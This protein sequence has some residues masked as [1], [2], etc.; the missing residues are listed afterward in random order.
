[1]IPLRL[2]EIGSATIVR[3]DPDLTITDVVTD[4]RQTRPDALFVCLRGE[5]HDGHDFAAEAAA[6]GAVA[7]LCERGRGTCAPAVP[8]LEAVNP[9]AALGDLARRVRRRSLAPVV[10]IAGAAG[11]TSTKDVL[12]ALLAPQLPTV[13]S[14]ASYNNEL[15]VP[16]TLA[17]LEPETAACVCELGTGAP[18]ELARLCRIAEPSLGVITAIGPEHLEFFGSAEAVAAE[19]AALIAALPSGAPLVLP[20][21]EDLLAPHRRT[22][23]D[24]WT[25]GLDERADVRPVAW[26]KA[27]A[28]TDARFLVRARPLAFTTNLRLPH[29]R[30]TLA[31]AIAAYAALG[32]PLERI[33]D[34]AARIALS[35]GRGEERRL[36]CGALLIDDAYNAN[37]VS[38][39]AGLEALVSRRNGGRAVAVLGGMAELGPQASRLH[40]RAA[41]QAAALGVDLLVAVGPA[42]RAY[43]DGATGQLE[44]R[45]LV[46]LDAATRALPA[47]LRPADV[48]LLKGS[49]ST[50]V[51]QLA[52]VLVD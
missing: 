14:P 39:A 34:G 40:A 30:L 25:F 43:L 33:V 42:A 50:G 29:H 9:L 37:P 8:T 4:S 5:R 2:R 16:L 13:A 20:L 3:G 6:G 35:P 21:D 49:H 52:Q 23:L 26:Q 46:D 28:G 18:G 31:A 45:W 22:D 11:K 51:G 27:A 44:C 41:R 24:E 32:L 10:G 36:R 19:E 1:M 48:I 15:G 47:M 7:I 12:G 17:L 38:L